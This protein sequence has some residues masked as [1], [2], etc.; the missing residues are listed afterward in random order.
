MQKHEELQVPYHSVNYEEEL[1]ENEAKLFSSILFPLLFWKVI[2]SS[3][4]FK[5]LCLYIERIN[6]QIKVN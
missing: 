1:V 5:I 3:K 4:Y 6:F 2:E